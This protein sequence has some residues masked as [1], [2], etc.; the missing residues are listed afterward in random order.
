VR[1][2]PW[3]VDFYF[4]EIGLVVEVDVYSTHASPW[5][6]ER[7]RAKTSALEDRGL[8]VHRVTDVQMK[9]DP[10]LVVGRIM[11]R[12]RDLTALRTRRS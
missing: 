10:A 11:R 3:E 4:R 5:A 7:D 12:I 6:F 8:S 9:R 2:G 1:I